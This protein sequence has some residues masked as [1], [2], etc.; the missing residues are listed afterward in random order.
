MRNSVLSIIVAL[1]I[2]LPV[3]GVQAEDTRSALPAQ[4]NPGGVGLYKAGQM[5]KASS[6]LIRAFT[7]YRSQMDRRGTAA[8]RP[9]GQLLQYVDGR[10]V[11]DARATGSGEDLLTDLR[12]L[13]L[14]RGARAGAVV[15]GLFPLAALDKAVT[16]ASLRSIAAS[17]RPIT[18]AGSIT[19][20]GD[21]ALRS[22]AARDVHGVDGTGVTVGVLSDAY[23]TLNGICR[24][25]VS[26]FSMVSLRCAAR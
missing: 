11:I 26:W 8:F 16:L 15:S 19:S 13:G 20:Q 4:Q 7:E 18:H 10:I 21:I 24:P 9:H 1:F 6:A 22:A 14:A 12:Q 25:M 17:P 23:D 2:G 3:L 5:S